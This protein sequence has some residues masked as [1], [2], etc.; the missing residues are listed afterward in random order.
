MKK[1]RSQRISVIV[2]SGNGQRVRRFSLQQWWLRAAAL[3]SLGSVVV[4]GVATTAAVRY[5]QTVTATEQIRVQN[6][7]F[8]QE[9]EQLLSRLG[10][11]EEAV[12]RA[13]RMVAR[14]EG[15]ADIPKQT[16]LA[17]GIG[18]I[19][20]TL[21]LPSL[22][23]IEHMSQ[24]RPNDQATQKYAFNNLQQKMTNLRD[25]AHT[26]ENRLTR[27]YGVKKQRGAFWA[28]QPTFWPIHGWVTSEFGPRGHTHVGGTRMHQGIDIAAPIG[29]EIAAAGDGVVAFAGF[30]GGY[31]R[32]LIIDHGFGITTLYAHASQLNVQEG[33]KIAR[34]TIVARSGNTGRSTGPH[35]HY[36]VAVDGVPVNPMRYLASR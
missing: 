1:P 35:L 29:T 6:A 8:D 32:C 31:G 9:R 4:A 25:T 19:T 16:E 28:A 12:D 24:L 33:Q 30:K 27:V 14:F 20:E 18:P 11:L 36:E 17:R 22:P 21:D 23:N 2:M 5:R 13:N 26:I 15:N 34:G 10:A 3:A 7:R